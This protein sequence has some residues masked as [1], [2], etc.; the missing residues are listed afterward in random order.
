MNAA[1]KN[2]RIFSIYFWYTVL[3][4]IAAVIC[5]SFFFVHKKSMVWNPDGTYQHY[6]AFLYYGKT[7]REFIKKLIFNRSFEFPMWEWGYASGGD[8]ISAEI[9][10]DPFFVLSVFFPTKLAEAGYSFTIILRLFL[11]GITFC[12]YCQKMNCLKWTTVLAAIMYTFC[13]FTFYAAPRHPYFINSMI[14]LPIIFLGI[15]KILNKET[16]V[17]FTLGV[18]ISALS[19]FYFFYMIVILTIMYV[20][21]RSFSTTEYRKIKVFGMNF[22][23]LFGAS[24]LGVM[25][26]AVTLFPVILS[27]IENNTRVSDSYIYNFFY[28][29][30][31]YASLPGSFVSPTLSAGD[32]A[33]V[34]MAPFV[35]I[36]VI[37]A[38]INR[39]KKQRWAKLFL[40]MEI[41]FLLFPFFGCMFNGFGY[42]TN[43]WVFV[44][45]FIPAYLFAKEFP[46][47][48]KYDSR[49]KAYLSA[50]C[51]VY[52]MLCFA[53]EKSRVEE[54]LMGLLILLLC[55]ILV[56]LSS[57][58]KKLE[59]VINGFHKSIPSKRIVQLSCV[60][61]SLIC[62]FN[63]AYYRFSK[64]ENNYTKEFKDKGTVNSVLFEDRTA[65]W[66]MISD[67][68][69]YRIDDA[70]IDNSQWNYPIFSH[71]PTTTSFWSL[72]SKEYIEWKKINNDYTERNFMFRGL[73]SRAWLQPQ[74]CAKYFVTT[75]SASA[76]ASVPYG[77][78]YQGKEKGINKDYY[79]YMT[80][81]SLAFGC[82]YDSCMRKS[83][84]ESLSVIER[85]Q[86][87][88]QSC[89]I[90]DNVNTKLIN[91]SP[92]YDDFEVNFELKC[93]D[94]T[95]IEGNTLHVKNK[96]AMITLNLDGDT[97][98]ELYVLVDGFSY[99]KG[100][101]S[102]IIT[103]TCSDAIYSVK[104]YTEKHIYSEGKTEY[105]FNLGYSE[106]ERNSISI[107][108]SDIGDYY[109]K[110]IRVICQP[111][112]KL[113]EYIEAR[114]EVAF[115][116]VEFST[117]KIIGTIDL[118]NSKLLCLSL[119]YSKG[120]SAY[121]DGKKVDIIRANIAFS[122]IMLEPGHHEIQLSFCTPY[123]KMGI[124]ISTLGLICTIVGGIL[125]KH[126]ETLARKLF[127]NAK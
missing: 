53:L 2:K 126:K 7:A 46:N 21:I 124:L 68:D 77:Y 88:L 91:S 64:S 60:F 66:K 34:G 27:F 61:L 55:L 31:Q 93:D 4:A 62:V 125:F 25:I 115:E 101:T 24:V 82:T 121:V 73:C 45:P 35:Y 116:N 30:N 92:E 78:V 57:N 51:V 26:S 114:N 43:R 67:T 95:F 83:D 89:V 52:V 59:I 120:W 5:F 58:F 6:N 33:K 100:S 97:K 39:D 107:K 50:G 37:G 108:F 10:Y 40:V 14:Y 15:E 11:A 38:F 104:H 20:I 127:K 29:L 56:L 85:Q 122:G 44:W 19:G 113:S 96:N 13:A 76:Q 90:D 117:N 110:N 54:N 23:K 112:E 98:G 79:L 8:I 81:N 48:L 18:A 106:N 49:K 99:K 63:I 118:D 86:A 103:A 72:N 87:A 75:N 102:A 80:D 3:F 16:F 70:E 94:Y 28:T 17:V 9:F 119:P 109:F 65:V 47:V 123:L 12:K 69:F 22:L 1:V 36:G 111:M 105:L 84:F 74:Y 32:W 71:Q 41:C 42:V